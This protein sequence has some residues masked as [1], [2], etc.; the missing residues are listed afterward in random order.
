[1]G[2]QQTPPSIALGEN[3]VSGR[4]SH[5]TLPSRRLPHPGTHSA[6]CAPFHFLRQY[7]RHGAHP[8]RSIEQRASDD[9]EGCQHRHLAEARRK[10][11]PGLHPAASRRRAPGHRDREER[12]PPDPQVSTAAPGLRPLRAPRSIPGGP[13]PPRG[14]RAPQQC[15]QTEPHGFLGSPHALEPAPLPGPPHRTS[16]LLRAPGPPHAPEAPPGPRRFRPPQPGPGVGSLLTA[17]DPFFTASCAYSTW[18]R[19]P[20]GEKTVMARS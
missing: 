13:L 1:M 6:Q 15:G 11:A 8:E 4:Q 14:L 17:V 3:L 18:K 12:A 10:D 7:Q 5:Q 2:P 16:R 19:W 9:K 20:S